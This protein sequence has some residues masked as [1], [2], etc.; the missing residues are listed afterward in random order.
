MAQVGFDELRRLIREEEAPRPSQRLSTLSREDA[1]TIS[2]NRR[3]EPGKLTSTIKG[4]LDWIVMRALDKDRNRRYATASDF[5]NDVDRY[6]SQQPVEARPPSSFYRFS[7]YAR[8][9]K[10]V[11]LTGSLISLAIILGLVFSTWQASVATIALRKARVAEVEATKAKDE[12]ELFTEHIKQANLLLTSAY[13]HV[14][15]GNWADAHDVYSRATEVQ[16][17]YFPVWIGRGSLYGKLGL[18]ELAAADYARALELGCPVDRVEFLGVS[19]L[20]LHTN[21]T[22]AYRQL[23]VQLKQSGELSRGAISR[24][25]LIDEQLTREDARRIAQNAEEHLAHASSDRN[26]SHS[27]LK[28]GQS[29]MPYGVRLYIAGWAHLR[30]GDL[31]QAVDR[32]KQANDDQNSWAGHGICYPLLAIAYHEMGES[33]LA[34]ELLTQSRSQLDLWL[35]ES[36]NGP[37]V[38][39]PIPWFDWI[40]FLINCDRAERLVNGEAGAVNPKLASRRARA[41]AVVK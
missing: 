5:A 1:S 10:I 8:R 31:S 19:Q 14:D 41:L 13:A 18:W 36:L 3:L 37:E 25:M 32:L 15:A 28:R 20:F 9:H 7:K 26:D 40:E 29:G 17:R 38:S 2:A 30:A 24:G 12:L 27:H 35:D 6:L 21:Q 4:D 34:D 23:S 22:S 16:P 11:L 39:L 33:E